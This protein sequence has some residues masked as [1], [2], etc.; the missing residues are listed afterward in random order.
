MDNMKKEEEETCVKVQARHCSVAWKYFIKNDGKG[1]VFCKL[2]KTTFKFSSNT[3]NMIKH[4]RVRHRLNIPA[5]A[6]GGERLCAEEP[7]HSSN[8]K[9]AKGLT[10]TP[11]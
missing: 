2:C 3:A 1:T 9:F 8:G 5:V 4:L 10:I 6:S 11:Y 7:A